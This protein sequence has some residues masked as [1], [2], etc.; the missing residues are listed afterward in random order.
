MDICPM[1]KGINQMLISRRQDAQFDSICEWSGTNKTLFF[2]FWDKG[3]ADETAL[4]SKR[5][6]Y[7]CRLSSTLNKHH[8]SG[9]NPVHIWKSGS[10]P[11]FQNPILKSSRMTWSTG[12]S[13]W[14]YSRILDTIGAIGAMGVP[15]YQTAAEWFWSF[16]V[17]IQ[18]E[19]P[20]F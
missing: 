13:N 9:Q 6:E 2:P 5:T 4:C 8:L 11:S 10:S 16:S 19:V 15:S 3:L 14:R 20:I 17:L 18:E 7:F 1:F 12:S